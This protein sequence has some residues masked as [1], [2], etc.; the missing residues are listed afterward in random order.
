MAPFGLL[1]I[2]AAQSF[3][4]YRLK[5]KTPEELAAI[6]ANAMRE[7]KEGRNGF[8]GLYAGTFVADQSQ[9]DR[10]AHNKMQIIYSLRRAVQSKGLQL[11]PQDSCISSDDCFLCVGRPLDEQINELEDVLRGDDRPGFSVL[12]S[13]LLDLCPPL[14]DPCTLPSTPIIIVDTVDDFLATCRSDLTGAGSVKH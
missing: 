2:K 7:L 5:D 11:P 8:L 14:L 9:R 3:T 1:I 12:P 13:L 4:D 6:E 10:S